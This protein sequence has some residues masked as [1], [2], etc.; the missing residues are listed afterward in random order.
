M[1]R[2]TYFAAFALSLLFVTSC[3]HRLTDF[4][5]ISTKNIELSKAGSFQR[6]SARNEGVDRVHIILSIPL[7]SPNLK[8]AIDRAIEATPGAVALVDGVV[9]TKWWWAILYG[10]TKVIVEGTPL[11]DP[12]IASTDQKIPAYSM[13]KLDKKGN[14]S[15]YVEIS[16]DEYNELK[17]NI[18]K[19]SEVKTFTS[20][21]EIE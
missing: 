18:V 1:K 4:T 2:I 17:S 20:L 21:T 15:E 6:G 8:E 9:Y 16:S 11:I 3:S 19:S 10:Q 12:A 7:G 13:A 5:I 14:V